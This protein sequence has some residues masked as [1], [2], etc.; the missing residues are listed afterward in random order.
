MD[1]LAGDAKSSPRRQDAPS[2]ATG[3]ADRPARAGRFGRLSPPGC[4]R[5]AGALYLYI[6]AAGTFAELFVRSKLVSFTDP[7]ATA[8][9][10]LA[11]ERLFRLGHAGE[12][13]HL[14]CDVGVTTILYLLFR[15]VDRVLATAATLMRLACIVILAMTELTSF[16]ALRLAGSGGYLAALEPGERHA[17]A[18]LAM[19]IHGDGYAVSLVF[20]GFGCLLT[21]LL[22]LRAGFLPRPLGFLMVAAGLSYLVSSFAQIL[23]PAFAARLFPAVF[24][25]PFVGEL[26]LALWLL[27]RGVNAAGWRERVRE[28]AADAAA[29]M[30]EG[31]T[32]PERSASTAGADPG[33]G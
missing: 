24:V 9:N 1:R 11:Q 33:L 2:V 17:L 25:P 7:A 18:L 30:R 19:K 26:S 21:G 14:A 15:P 28:H 5:V 29:W 3:D 22:I 32:W 6:I 8:R 12:I 10:L 27:V 16:A 23:D 20:F 31:R 13:L 4:A